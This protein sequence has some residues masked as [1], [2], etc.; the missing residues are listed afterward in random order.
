MKNFFYL[1]VFLFFGP[2]VVLAADTLPRYDN[3]GQGLFQCHDNSS[4]S[5]DYVK[6]GGVIVFWGKLQPNNENEF[7]RTELN[8]LIDGIK[9]DGKKT[10]LHFMI[11]PGNH[12]LLDLYPAWLKVTNEG[13]ADDQIEMI[14]IFDHWLNG[15]KQYIYY[16]QPW[17]IKYHQKLE[18]FLKLLNVEFEKAGII[19]SIEYIEP[20]LGGQWGCTNLWFPIRGEEETP[21]I[22]RVFA[23]EAGCGETDW[24]CLG[25]RFNTGVDKI[26]DI[27][28]ES[29]PKIPLMLIGGACRYGE[30]S[31]DGFNRMIN[32]YG[33]KVMRKNAGL[34]ADDST[35]G[36]RPSEFVSCDGIN[37]K[38]K[39]GQEPTG[40]GMSCGGSFNKTTSTCAKDTLRVTSSSDAVY[41]K[42]YRESLRL[43]AISYYC[44]YRSDLGCNVYQDTNKMVVDKLGAQVAI[45]K[46]DLK[47][48]EVMTGGNINIEITWN[49]AG[50]TALV[51]PLKQGLKWTASSYK[52]FVEFELNGR[53]E[54]YKEVDINPSSKSWALGKDVLTTFNFGI[55]VSLGGESDE[56][57]TNYKVYVGLTDPN[58][59]RKRFAL[60]NTNRSNEV[61]KRRYLLSKTLMVTGKRQTEIPVVPTETLVPLIPTARPDRGGDV[62]RDGKVDMADY[63]LWLSEYREYKETGQVKNDW[64][65][66]LNE[67][68]KLD[69]LDFF[70][71]KEDYL[72][73]N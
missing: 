73:D 61:E 39:C 35:C 44:M 3:P 56:S 72:F 54:G 31:Y 14:R 42:T 19:D 40:S 48:E 21:P 43:E 57:K 30:C 70:I 58:G 59:E 5:L 52:L 38:T 69:M 53:V 60:T 9:K 23:R 62:N 28:S 25:R 32:K 46:S 66:D 41:D 2:K 17:G 50:I 22:L 18:K 12:P 71:W 64:Q 4:I 1:L 15:V 55:P 11:Y 24:T 67:D 49:N 33:M 27:Y 7:D 45:M 6:G 47:T 29:F 10:Y 34:G 16:P 63:A 26:I 8:K 13:E 37:A 36:L 65:G 68:E 20:A 51:A